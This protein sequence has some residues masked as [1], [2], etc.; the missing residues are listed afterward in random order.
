M[1]PE[2]IGVFIPIIFFLVAGLIWVSAIY[3]RSRER[4][5]LIEKGLS[6][7]Q[8]KEYFE[9]KSFYDNK[10]R[11]SYI[12]MQIG[13]ICVFFG[14]GLGIGLILQDMTDKDYW[15]VLFIFTFTG[16][17]FI[18]ANLLARRLAKKESN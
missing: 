2:I 10:K 14:L 17:G 8:I 5:M 11:D 18:L 9:R 13:I 3:L 16:V 7:D 12:L 1:G 15:I 4:Q 6:A